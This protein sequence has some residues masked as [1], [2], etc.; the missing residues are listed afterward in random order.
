MTLMN[1]LLDARMS[2]RQVAVTRIGVA[3]AVLLGWAS[4]A[5][6]LPRLA[7]P[8]VLRVPY[9][10]WFPDPDAPLVRKGPYRFMRHPNY[11]VVVLEIALLPLALG[12]WPLAL[13]F[14][15]VNAILLAWRIR[16]EEIAL[17]TR[18]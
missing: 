9:V 5:E 16:A 2:A 8:G 14:S 17:A 12:S 18:R 13:G 11:L 6:T 15:I 4:S 3:L 1:R 7:E 10:G